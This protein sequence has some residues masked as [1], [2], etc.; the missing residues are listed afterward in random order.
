[1]LRFHICNIDYYKAYLPKWPWGAVR[2]HAFYQVA[3]AA[4]LLTRACRYSV[5]WPWKPILSDTC[6]DHFPA[7][8]FGIKR[9]RKHHGASLVTLKP[10]NHS[11]LLIYARR[12]SVAD[13]FLETLSTLCYLILPS[14]WTEQSTRESFRQ[15]RWWG[16]PPR[17]CTGF[18]ARAVRSPRRCSLS[19]QQVGAWPAS[20]SLPTLPSQPRSPL[21]LDAPCLCSQLSVADVCP[22]PSLPLWSVSPTVLPPSCLYRSP[23]NST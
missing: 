22:P 15:T 16:Q 10:F 14:R 4:L 9:N 20:L 3:L 1:M 13:P 11:R 2:W 12:V 5:P 21:C 19:G 6:W 17:T 8:S 18:E 23:H 7:S